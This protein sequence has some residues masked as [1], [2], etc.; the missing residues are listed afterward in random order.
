[1][2]Q[3]KMSGMW[4]CP[5]DY[6]NQLYFGWI[7]FILKI[8]I[9]FH[10]SVLFSF[11]HRCAYVIVLFVRNYYVIYQR[12]PSKYNCWFPQERKFVRHINVFVFLWNF[13]NVFPLQANTCVEEIW[14]KNNYSW[15]LNWVLFLEI[16]WYPRQFKHLDDI[17]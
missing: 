7:Y 12:F 3:I 6:I 10:S 9:L 15:W 1:M 5:I 2:K 13:L 11:L 14:L 8:K 17:I 16:L 4:F